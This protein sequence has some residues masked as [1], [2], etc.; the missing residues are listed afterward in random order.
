MALMT[1]RNLASS[2]YEAAE[3]GEKQ[4]LKGVNLEIEAGSIH[5][6]MGTNGS[7]KSTLAHVLAGHPLHHVSGGTVDFNGKDL[8]AMGADERS[9]AGLFLAFQ[10]PM[11]ISGL[12]VAVFLKKAVEA[13][14]GREVSVREFQKELK[15]RMKELQIPASFLNRS[16]NEAF[17]GGEKK[18]MEIL[19]MKLL[20]PE[21]VILDETDSGLDVDALRLLFGT[22]A[23]YAAGSDR[24]EGGAEADGNGSRPSLLIITH[25]E[26]VLD[27]ISP[28]Y[29]HIMQE[30]KI[31][32]IGGVELGHSINAEGFEAAVR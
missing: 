12:P 24:E 27:Y 18:R 29:V 16:I 25:Y 15:A 17:S 21:L 22:I 1:I 23:D 20:R 26:R 4:I 30:G 9:R 11:A 5:L 14:R 6:L 31:V 10:Y 19:Q 32:R 3:E 7:G 2:A 8:L 13:R 28:D